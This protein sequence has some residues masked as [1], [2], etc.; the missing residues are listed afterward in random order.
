M[1]NTGATS[2]TST[3]KQVCS[4]VISEGGYQLGGSQLSVGNPITVPRTLT[5]AGTFY[6]VVSLRL[7]TTRLDA[8]AILTA[9]SILGI[10]NNANYKWQVV[11]SGTTTGGTW[12]SAGTNS[13]VEYNITGTAFTTGTG[14][15]LASG[16]FQGSNQGSSAVDILK[17]ALFAF[18]L[19]RNPFVPTMYELTLTCTSAT[20]GDQVLASL[21]WE[22]I[23]R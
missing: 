22:E 16:F 3:L 4:T 2:G 12:V 11:A 10:T 8:I 20:N 19:E 14:R 15:V 23:S 5:T 17:A 1:T 21:D 13:S 7:K 6:P 9:V 18:Q